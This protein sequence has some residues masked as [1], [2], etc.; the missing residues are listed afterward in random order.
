MSLNIYQR[1]N[2]IR[3]AVEYIKKDKQVA[4]RYMA[5]THDMV[6]A[7]IRPHLVA[8]GVAVVPCLTSSHVADSGTTTSKGVPIIRYEARYAVE[9]VNCDEPA[10]K[11]VMTVEAHAN[12]EGDKAPGKAISYAT[13]YAMLKMFNIETGEADEGRIEQ[14]GPKLDP[15]IVAKLDM[16]GSLDVLKSVWEK[17][18]PEQRK[19]HQAPKDEAKKRIDKAEKEAA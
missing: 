12:D 11:V 6:T 14:E 9:F 4:G 15:V 19:L 10:D 5:V 18:T 16:C 3:K 13:K 7:E 8:Q 17:L 1:L 2:E